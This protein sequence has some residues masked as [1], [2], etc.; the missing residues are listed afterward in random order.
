MLYD[1]DYFLGDCEGYRDFLRT[2][3][4]KPS[5]RIAKCI[6][7]LHVQPGQRILD[8]GCGRGEVSLHAAYSGA[9][10]VAVDAS[11]EALELLEEARRMWEKN[12]GAGQSRPMSLTTR[13]AFLQQLPIETEWADSVVLSDVIEHIPRSEIP[14]IVA[15]CYRVLRS[16]GRLVIHTQ[17]NRILVDYTVPILSRISWL[18]GVS[19]P[20]DLR[21]EMT[22]GSGIVYHPS[23]QTRR[24]LDRSLRQAGFSIQ[25]LWLEGSYPVHR[26]LGETRWKQAVLHRFR[27]SRIL[28][29]FL[30]SQIFAVARKR[31]LSRKLPPCPTP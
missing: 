9:E 15:E 16:G 30:A 3:G 10:V 27:R 6:N 8:L 5:R 1:R 24:E 18:W 19:L 29:E 14:L 7:L 31:D 23:E 20:R 13:C 2:H 26:I 22:P 17:P 28:K 12:Y 25:D 11:S 4:W 21:D